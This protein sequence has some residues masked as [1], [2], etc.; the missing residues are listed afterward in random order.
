MSKHFVLKA[1]DRKRT[2]S[3]MLKLMRREGYIP[4]VIYG[5]NVENRNVKVSAASFR[6]MIAHSA[7]ANVLVDLEL[8]GG[9]SQL[10][11]V[12]D[13][14]HDPLS[15]AVLHA[16]FLAVN[17][18]S[19]ITAAIPVE[20]IGD[21]E[22][23]KLGGQ[24]E[25]LLYTVEIK[26]RPNDLPETIKVD[27][28]HL[29]VGDMLN[30]GS[31]EWPSGVTPVLNDDVVIAMVAKARVAL[32]EEGEEETGLEGEEEATEPEVVGEEKED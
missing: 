3:G 32:A 16:D 31:V 27:V 7:S 5:G 29:D 24:L 6:E 17:T 4:S 25:Q 11:F 9:A 23:V 30:V 14:Q 15:G 13:L 21:P 28:E 19:E 8:D 2:G 22:G 26:C 18:D 20:L 10:A 12:K 1:E